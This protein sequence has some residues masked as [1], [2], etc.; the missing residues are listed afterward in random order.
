M[1]FVKQESLFDRL[2][3]AGWCLLAGGAMAAA[4]TAPPLILWIS[5]ES[6]PGD[7]YTRGTITRVW[8][9]L[10]FLYIAVGGVVLKLCRVA[11]LK[12]AAQV[13]SPAANE[14]GDKSEAGGEDNRP[15]LS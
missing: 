3:L 7:R 9:F 4:L 10:S 12:P 15:G 8:L 1:K 14:T 5:P 13:S 2:T 11:L 6:L